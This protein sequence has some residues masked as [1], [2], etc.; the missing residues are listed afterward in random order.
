MKTGNILYRFV[1]YFEKMAVFETGTER[2]AVPDQKGPDILFFDV[3]R[4]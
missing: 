1:F 2:Q 4:D 3:C